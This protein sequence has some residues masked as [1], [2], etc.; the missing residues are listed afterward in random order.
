MKKFLSLVLVFVCVV[1]VAGC[2]K[3][4][5]TCTGKLEGQEA[6]VTGT[7]KGDTVTN[8]KIESTADANSEKEAEQ[9]AALINGF[10]SLAKDQ[11]ITMSAK[12][13]GK[14]VTTTMEIDVVKASKSSSSS[15]SAG[16]DLSDSSKDKIIKALEDEGLTCK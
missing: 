2:S 8:L 6:T 16:F 14:T 5:F 9:G 10:G 15:S 7:T 11:G 1:C 13:S 4:D 3:A 12:V